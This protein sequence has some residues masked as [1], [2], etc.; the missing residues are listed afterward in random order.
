[1]V[2]GDGTEVLYRYRGYTYKQGE[3]RGRVG[4]E[5]GGKETDGCPFT[6]SSLASWTFCVALVTRCDGSLACDNDGSG[7]EI[8]SLAGRYPMNS[9]VLYQ[10]QADCG[11]QNLP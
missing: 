10:L 1:M 7:V 8:L 4:K 11:C 2:P 3:L 5:R 9:A 6:L